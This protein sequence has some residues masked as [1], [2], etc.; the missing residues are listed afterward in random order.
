M[1]ASVGP[2]PSSSY[3]KQWKSDSSVKIYKSVSARSP[4][5]KSKKKNFFLLLGFSSS[6]WIQSVANFFKNKKIESTAI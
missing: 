5:T 6:S 3:P 1:W 2:G 4:L